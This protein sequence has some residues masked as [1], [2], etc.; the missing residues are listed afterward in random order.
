MLAISFATT[1]QAMLQVFILGAIG[2]ALV[3]AKFL[4]VEAIC[5]VK[6]SCRRAAVA[7]TKEKIINA[8]V[9]SVV[10]MP[11]TISTIM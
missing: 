2:Y 10:N 3:K 8:P 7:N 9:K 5:L 4:K 11:P 6:P 1:F